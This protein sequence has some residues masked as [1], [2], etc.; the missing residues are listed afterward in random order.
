[1]TSPQGCASARP[2]A[3]RANRLRIG[4]VKYLNAQP[5]VYGWRGE[6]EFDHPAVLCRKL[7]NA[8]LEVALV[9]SFEFL[10]DPVYTIVDGVA[11]AADG[12]VYSV[13]VAHDAPLAELDEIALDPAS[14]TSVNLLRCLLAERG[15]RPRLID[16]G[17]ETIARGKRGQLL[18]GDQAIRFRQQHRGEVQVW[19][20]G[21]AWH[22]LTGLPFVFALWLVRPEVHAAQAIADQLRARRDENSVRLNDVIAAQTGF[23]SEF[24]GRYFRDCLRFRFGDAE[25][26][27]LL[28]F[29]SLCEKH[30]ILPPNATP[31][32]LI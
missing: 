1:V 24:C 20:L 8:E 5:L 15:L 6:V 3:K 7:A 18:I 4:C 22:E 19:D 10:R 11:V 27:G 12:P 29:R 9:S 2:T 14:N 30:G 26:R 32:R 13:F 21:A 31:L 17:S 25:K 16:A 28:M 23:P